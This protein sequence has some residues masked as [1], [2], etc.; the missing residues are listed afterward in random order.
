MCLFSQPRPATPPPPK[1]PAAPPPPAPPAPPPPP[2][3][4]IQRPMD[5]PTVRT[6]QSRKERTGNL[7]KGTSSLR[8]PLN[9]P[10]GGGINQG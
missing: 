1:L 7:A 2:P 4:P 8:I 9:V 6:Q 10:S 3:T 5:E